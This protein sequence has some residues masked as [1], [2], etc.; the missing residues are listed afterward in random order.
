MQ[1]VGSTKWQG[2]MW[3]QEPQQRNDLVYMYLLFPFD[4]IEHKR[5]SIM[6]TSAIPIVPVQALH[7]ISVSIP[8]V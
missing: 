5:R 6:T 8:K 1:H 4:V 7:V 2:S 3:Y